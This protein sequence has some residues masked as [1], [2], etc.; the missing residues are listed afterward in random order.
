MKGEF[1]LGCDFMGWIKDG[2]SIDESRTSA[3]IL[4]LIVC[5]GV[6]VYSYTTRG[7]FSDNLL[8]LTKT[9]IYAVAG[10]NIL[11][12]TVGNTIKSFFDK[13]LNG[14]QTNTTTTTQDTNQTKSSI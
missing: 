9:L 1:V 5:I 2:V 11:N 14:S 8:E 10:V 13:G 6:S 4:S 3:T 12:N 7:D